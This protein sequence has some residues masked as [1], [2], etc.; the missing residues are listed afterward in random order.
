M[1]V[2]DLRQNERQQCRDRDPQGEDQ[3]HPITSDSIAGLRQQSDCWAIVCVIRHAAGIP[4]GRVAGL[5]RSS[6][7]DNV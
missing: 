2:Q 6:G 3:L 4:R 5:S 7:K 1:Q